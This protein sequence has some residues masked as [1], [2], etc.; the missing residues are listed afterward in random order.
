MRR[1]KVGFPSAVSAAWHRHVMLDDRLDEDSEL[2]SAVDSLLLDADDDHAAST[3]RA[4]PTGACAPNLSSTAADPAASALLMMAQS[5]MAAQGPPPTFAEFANVPARNPFADRR[6]PVIIISGYVAAGKTTLVNRLLKAAK[7]GG[8]LRVGVIAHRQ[9]EEFGVEPVRLEAPTL[10]HYSDAVYD[11]GSGCICCSPKGELTRLLTDLAWRQKDAAEGER[12]DVLVLRLG[13]LAAPLVFAKAVCTLGDHFTLASIISV[14]DAALAPR[15]LAKGSAEWQANAQIACADLVLVNQHMPA[16]GEARASGT[17]ASAAA[18]ATIMQTADSLVH[19]ISPDMDIEPMPTAA[20][21]PRLLALLRRRAHFSTSRAASLDPDFA[22]DP[23]CVA[24]VSMLSLTVHDNRLVAACAVEDGPLYA[25]RLRSL[26]DR[27][28]ASGSVLRVKGIVE[29]LDDDHDFEDSVHGDGGDELVAVEEALEEAVE[30]VKEIAERDS[31]NGGRRA[32]HGRRRPARPMV[33]EGVEERIEMRAPPPPDDPAA[34]SNPD[35]MV[36]AAGTAAHKLFVL[37]R[38]LA[39]GSLRRDFQACR[40]PRG[41]AFA[42]D[43]ELHFVRKLTAASTAT[44]GRAQRARCVASE[45]LPGVT[46]VQTR[47][48]SSSSC[49]ASGMAPNLTADE[50]EFVAFMRPAEGDE[51]D[52]T[53]D[54]QHGPVAI[55]TPATEASSARS[56]RLSDGELLGQAEVEA[57]GEHGGTRSRLRLLPV[58]VIAGAVYVRMS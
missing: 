40:V 43:T 39:V 10:A 27:L 35:G 54:E 51:V 30:E 58:V 44:A 8:G 28:A 6:L 1:L 42:A 13:P 23:N 21:T 56:Y 32:C 17:T 7:E 50:G 24:P 45:S 5:F 55:I 4:S 29:V 41:F 31:A 47:V 38:D 48:G 49:S 11:F 9:A 26:L 52:V 3:I 15:H 14:C 37:G 53:D 25:A 57:R 2:S 20:D 22:R 18:E 33:I 12:L 34:A 36:G 19:A 46:V 16:N